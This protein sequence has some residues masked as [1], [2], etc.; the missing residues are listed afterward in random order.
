MACTALGVATN[1]NIEHRFCDPNRSERE[2]MG[3][4]SE[5]QLHRKVFF[6]NDSDKDITYRDTS[7]IILPSVS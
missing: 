6:G 1:L 2:T 7:R 5:E 4:P 3:I